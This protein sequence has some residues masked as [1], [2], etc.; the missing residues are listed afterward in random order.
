[1]NRNVSKALWFY[2]ATQRLVN[3]FQHL[4]VHFDLSLGNLLFFG[5][6]CLCSLTQLVCVMEAGTCVD[7]PPLF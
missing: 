2:T 3:V 7:L 6:V 5:G 4:V 1:M